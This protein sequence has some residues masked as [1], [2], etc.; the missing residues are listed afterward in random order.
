MRKLLRMFNNKYLC[1][2][3]CIAYLMINISPALAQN[4]ERTDR[5][6][7]SFDFLGA[8]L[9][10]EIGSLDVEQR[11]GVRL[12]GA[13]LRLLRLLL[14]KAF[15]IAHLPRIMIFKVGLAL[16]EPTLMHLTI[17]T[18]LTSALP[19]SQPLEI[20]ISNTHSSVSSSSMR[21]GC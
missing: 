16:V 1:S 18:A 12:R 13:S 6:Y 5:I 4:E 8:K 19:G 20:M 9:N 11:V 21:H 3:A 17:K 2:I 10:K 7:Y 14:Q 15:T